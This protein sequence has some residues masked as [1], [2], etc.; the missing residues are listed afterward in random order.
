MNINL[1]QKVIQFTA[2][3]HILNKI[4][5]I[6]EDPILFLLSMFNENM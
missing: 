2:C 1:Q 6:G 4:E 5:G 3:M